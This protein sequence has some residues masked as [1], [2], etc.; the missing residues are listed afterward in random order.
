MCIQDIEM[1]CVTVL[2]KIRAKS[3]SD[4]AN[5]D[6]VTSIGSTTSKNYQRHGNKKRTA[7][8]LAKYR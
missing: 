7:R 4:K 3:E 5:L 2:N 8:R 1:V 6:I